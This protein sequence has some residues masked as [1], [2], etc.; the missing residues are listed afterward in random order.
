VNKNDFGHGKPVSGELLATLIQPI[1][2][3]GANPL[4]RANHTQLGLYHQAFFAL[5]IGF[6]RLAKLILGADYAVE[7]KGAWMTDQALKNIGHD[8]SALLDA[9]ELISAQHLSDKN[10]SERPNEPVVLSAKPGLAGRVQTGAGSK[11]GDGIALS[12]MERD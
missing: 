8:I 1:P 2:Q 4:G 12:A 3:C 5:S 6:E 7:N 9:C 10:W 11:S